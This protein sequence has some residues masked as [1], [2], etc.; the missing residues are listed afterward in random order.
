MAKQEPRQP[1]TNQSNSQQ[2]APEPI[3]NPEPVLLDERSLLACLMRAVPAE[4]NAKISMKSTV[5]V[6]IT[7][8]SFH[9]G[10]GFV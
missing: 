1:V 4:A 2:G 6:S 7:N 5:S 3:K 9:A 10:F 8:E